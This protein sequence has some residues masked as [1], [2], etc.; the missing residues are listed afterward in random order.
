MRKKIKDEI[1]DKD[2]DKLIEMFQTICQRLREQDSL[3]DCVKDIESKLTTLKQNG[4][5]LI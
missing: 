1:F 4:L 3:K 2:L 5:N